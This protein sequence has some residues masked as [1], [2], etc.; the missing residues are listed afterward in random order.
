MALAA[1]EEIKKS[2]NH[3][4]PTLAIATTEQGPK[5]TQ[6]PITNSGDGKNF[7]I[8]FFNAVKLLKTLSA[9]EIEFLMT[10]IE[11]TDYG[12]NPDVLIPREVFKTTTLHSA[13]LKPTREK[14]EA[15]GY[16]MAIQK[17]TGSGSAAWHYSLKLEK[18]SVILQ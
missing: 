16:I 10:V 9:S 3:P 8:T 14:L 2:V 5:V 13:M 18:F 6:A 11:R 17:R 7:A 12:A 4:T 1:V 15:Y